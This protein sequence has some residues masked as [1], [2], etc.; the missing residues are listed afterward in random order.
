MSRG[1]TL[2]RVG[3]GGNIPVLACATD[4]MKSSLLCTVLVI[5]LALPF[6]VS[7]AASFAYRGN[8]QDA[9]RPA[10][11]S[12]DLELTLYSAAQGGKVIG[13]P[14]TVYKV[15]VHDGTFITQADL[16]PLTNASGSAYLGVK[17]RSAGSGEFAALSTRALIGTDTA[18]SCPGSWGI[19]GNAGN[20]SSNYLGTSDNQPIR[21]KVNGSPAGQITPGAGVSF[22]QGSLF[23]GAIASGA[24]S[25]AVGE[26]AI[27]SG[28]TSF[29]AGKNAGAAQAGNFMWGDSQGSTGGG[30]TA[31]TAP[32]QY[33]VRAAGGVAING[34]PKDNATELSI[35]PSAVNGGNYPSIFLGNAGR[36]GGILI[37]S[38]DESSS[39]SN[40][41]GFYIDQYNGTTQARK[42]IVD[43]NGLSIHSKNTVDATYHPALSVTSGASSSAYRV[44]T[45]FIPDDGSNGYL[46]MFSEAYPSSLGYGVS[47][48]FYANDSQ[49]IHQLLTTGVAAGGATSTT[50]VGDFYVS[51]NAYKPGGG[52]WM[53]SSDRRIKQD[54]APIHAALDTVMKLR[55]VNF[56]YTPE[57]RA[58][59]GGLADRPYAGFIAQEYA[60]VFPAD[61]FS[62]REHVPG[63]PDSDPNILAL[64]SNA[65]LINTVAAVQELAT[66]DKSN[67]ERITALEREN[68]RVKLQNGEL[69]HKLDSVL[70]RLNQLENSSRK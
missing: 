62:T 55:P 16:G 3:K 12:Y 64:D 56:H 32:D 30:I 11:G 45:D 9:G 19:A 59:A 29:A 50:V 40:D 35:Y 57:Y 24:D 39:T 60:E 21:F 41:A 49:G 31:T 46:Q 5:A 7:H 65:A 20:L 69:Q 68:A 1:A 6:T 18:T 70:V 10:E 44:V 25:F 61:V 33:I 2:L 42:L 34:A 8:L 36:T 37:G 17:V 4:A 63:V 66:L 28:Q 23:G 48:A 52:S 51:G 27:A 58:M 38:G 54:I 15:A 43:S 26:G 13:G 22:S 67:S 53:A 47:M 14:L